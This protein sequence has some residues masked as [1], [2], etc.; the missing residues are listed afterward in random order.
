MKTSK[1]NEKNG[2]SKRN[3]TNLQASKQMIFSSSGVS[4]D[5][6]SILAINAYNSI[7][8]YWTSNVTAAEEFRLLLE[9]ECNNS[10]MFLTTQDS[11]KINDSL[12]YEAQRK[13]MLNI[14]PEIHNRFPKESPFKR[15][16]FKKCS[17]VG[18][19]GILLGSQCGNEID[20][21]EFVVRFNFAK[22]INFM[23][24][25]GSKTSLITCN[26]S[27]LVSRYSRLAENRTEMFRQDVKTEYGN[28]TIYI[29]AFAYKFCTEIAF[30]AQ[31]VLNSTHNKVIFPHPGHMMSATK[32]WQ[33]RGTLSKHITSGLLFS[34]SVIPFCKEVHLFG[35]WPFLKDKDGNPLSFHYF[36]PKQA[37]PTSRFQGDVHN[38]PSEFASMI[39][40]H[41]KGI[42]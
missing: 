31:D 3:I 7:N 14:T 11:V 18:S 41:N 8:T 28:T 35:F 15:N 25:V 34:T 20:S 10:N 16:M 9:K 32:F 27:I 4:N 23:D 1:S 24:D 38:M 2:N 19:S 17:I 22:T 21:A 39:N 29:P 36:G 26:P 13:S 5:S 6:Q 40:L 12:E 37:P 33:G 42:I 30:R